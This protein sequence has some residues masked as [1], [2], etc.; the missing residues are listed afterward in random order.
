ME[1]KLLPLFV[2]VPMGAAFLVPLL[3]KVWQGF[4]ELLSNLA[5]SVL[6]GL[7]C[8]GV[9]YMLTGSGPLICR[10]GG[11]APTLGITLVYDQ[12]TVLVV[13]ALNLI[14]FCGLL[15]SVRFLDGYTGRWKFHTLYLLVL[16]GLNGVAITGDMFNIFV[17][18]EI[19]AVASYALV[20]FGTDFEELEG[21]FKY[22]VIG[23]IGGM[24]ILL[25]IALMYA[26]ASTL[27]MAV[28]SQALGAMGQTPLFWFMAATFLI[29]FAVKMGMVPFHA[30]MPDAY[31][32][33]PA[34][35]AAL[36][37]G[38]FS[39]VVGVYA[40][41]R[42]LF[43]VFGLSRAN[44]PHFFNL[45]VAVGLVSI[46]AGALWA[47]NQ[48]DYKRML[49]YSS[50]S[51]IGYIVLGLGLGNWWGVVG[52]LLHIV[53]HA[54]GKSTLFLA[55]GS[56]ENGTGVRDMDKLRGLE[57][58]MPWTTW[59]YM[60]GSFSLA[61]VPPFVGFFSK[62]LIILGALSARMYWLAILAALFSAVTLGYFVRFINKA[63]FA[64]PQAEETPARES[65]ATMVV[66]MVLLVLVSLAVGI[67]FKPVLDKVIG[68]AAQVLLDGA[69]Y[70]RMVL[71][72]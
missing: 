40:M 50:V 16:T 39:K 35:V 17:F 6:L 41:S 28:V 66:A 45:L 9:A 60:L 57:Q 44:A 3:S 59:T 15:Y 52:A 27:N 58:R 55:S 30:W 5:S 21:G 63:F 72:G 2:A 18:I 29:G 62:V 46:A 7:S 65:A 31:P 14:G 54:L 69:A 42:V 68:P 47:Y 25:A 61:G 70:A 1:S 22:M 12:L 56:I 33:A 20:A 53:T 24:A 19:S 71:G 23:E 48:K 49:A 8:V 38:V 67:G 32:S 51:Q 37:S 34:P 11:W 4:A 36:L 43:C 13:L 10:M 64:R 26:R